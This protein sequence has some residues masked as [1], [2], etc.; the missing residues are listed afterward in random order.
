MITDGTV[1]C[2]LPHNTIIA[3]YRIVSTLWFKKTRTLLYISNNFSIE[4]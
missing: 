3:L 1:Q 4:L 2:A